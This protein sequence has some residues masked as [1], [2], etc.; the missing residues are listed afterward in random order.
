VIGVVPK[1]EYSS[2]PDL[3]ELAKVAVQTEDSK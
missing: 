2:Y 1:F 3:T